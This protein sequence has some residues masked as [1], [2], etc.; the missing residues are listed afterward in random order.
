MKKISLLVSLLLLTSLG[1]LVSCDENTS[2]KIVDEIKV[3]IPENDFVVGSTINLDDYI[4]C[5]CEGTIVNKKYNATVLTEGMASLDG[6]NLTIL[7]E[8]TINVEISVDEQ[9]KTFTISTISQLKEKFKTTTE[10]VGKK[11]YVDNTT[12]ENDAIHLTGKGF[13]HN[14]S[15][16]AYC[17]DPI[18]FPNQDLG[19]YANKWTGLIQTYYSETYSFSMDDG[20][21]TNLNV[22]P[23]KQYSIEN[24][25]LNQEFPL[26]YDVFETKN[27][28]LVTTNTSIIDNWINYSMGT[29]YT[30]AELGIDDY[31]LTAEFSNVIT[32]DN[33]TIEA[34]IISVYTYNYQDSSTNITYTEEEPYLYLSNAVL[35]DK[36][37]Y[38][39]PVLNSYITS[40]KKPS[41]LSHKEIIEAFEPFVNSKTYTLESSFYYTDYDNK[42][43][44]EPSG[45]TIPNETF[46]T[47]V[48]QYGFLTE[49]NDGSISGIVNKNDSLYT[50]SNTDFNGNI[51]ET[52]KATKYTD[53]SIS[54]TD[55]WGGDFTVY[56]AS[57]FTQLNLY[58]SINVFSNEEKEGVRTIEIGSYSSDNFFFYAMY[59]MPGWGQSLYELLY[60]SSYLMYCTAYVTITN[61]D[62][63]VDVQFDMGAD[64][65]Y[66][67]QSRYF[68]NN[69]DKLSN[70][71]DSLNINYTA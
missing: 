2:S 17:Y 26:S 13:L 27:N 36:E 57:T 68:D 33:E 12:I 35:F 29:I 69:I 34:L 50:I 37:Y 41:A 39:I 64:T 66:H 55:I 45:S 32:Q 11:Y 62:V 47:Y 18:L 9:T 21:G 10:N 24:Y 5:Y 15:Y 23:G 61:E 43:T 31:K 59:N 46:Y 56:L 71:L 70:E 40:R 3:I 53:S 28:Q 8:G 20:K 22:L 67:M 44:E 52:A 48:N 42:P 38:S 63:V 1:T 49:Y 25:Y 60:E 65:I 7:N 30:P 19:E 51:T 6:H 14:N 54:S 58:S 16:F 4:K